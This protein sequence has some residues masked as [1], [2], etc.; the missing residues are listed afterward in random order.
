MASYSNRVIIL[1]NGIRQE[2]QQWG[3]EHAPEVDPYIANRL[4]VIIKALGL[5]MVPTPLA[6]V[7]P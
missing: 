6:G 2:G 4:S 1:N 5:V 3:N 7:V